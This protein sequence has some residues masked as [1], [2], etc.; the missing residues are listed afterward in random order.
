MYNNTIIQQNIIKK[1][2]YNNNYNNNYSN[3]L[4]VKLIS[5]LLK[6]P[7]KHKVLFILW[8]DKNKMSK[9]RKKAI[10][11]IIN[12]SNCNVIIVTP[13]NLHLF[14]KKNYPLHKSYQFLSAVHRSDYL[15]CYLM[16]HY[17]GGYSD[18]KYVK[19]DWSKNYSKLINNSDIWIIGTMRFG[20]LSLS[21]KYSIELK[22]N[23][24]KSSISTGF[25]ICKPYTL[26]TKEW[27][28]TIHKI[29]DE[30]FDLLQKYPAKIP[31][32][33]CNLFSKEILD[34]STYPIKWF[35]ILAEIFDPLQIKY[36]QYIKHGIPV[37][38][39]NNYM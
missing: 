9:N 6:D 23:K 2:L 31:R 15:R 25:F 36:K 22:T 14:I 29:L 20:H 10:N 4:Y 5:Y 11:L 3:I 13:Q 28:N 16:H 18:I 12:T 38:Y 17:G 32:E 39:T 24:N 37:R 26:F 35:E 7:I 27:Y 30:K 33:N 8:T 1:I 34:N 19:G 21:D